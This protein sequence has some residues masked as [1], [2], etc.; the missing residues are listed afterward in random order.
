MDCQVNIHVGVDFIDENQERSGDVEE[1]IRG[2][3]RNIIY[4]L[5]RKYMG[6]NVVEERGITSIRYTKLNTAL[7]MVIEFY[8]DIDTF[9]SEEQDD[10]YR[11]HIKCA[12]TEARP[13][14]APN[15]ST[16]VSAILGQTY[17]DE[18]ITTDTLKKLY[19][20]QDNGRYEFEYLG[21][22]EFAGVEKS[23]EL[24]KILYER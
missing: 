1:H 16:F 9:Q 17:D 11:L 4:N 21:E 5:V 23:V 10:S 7:R 13:D 12:I 22:K 14:G 3:V 18:I 2:D 24:Y 19:D 8:R 6:L 20:E 15:L